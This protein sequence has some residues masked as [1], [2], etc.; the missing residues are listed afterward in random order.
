MGATVNTEEDAERNDFRP[1]LRSPHRVDRVF[2]ESAGLDA[3]HVRFVGST[4]MGVP[5]YEILGL[6]STATD[7]QGRSIP[8]PGRGY[9]QP[10]E[11]RARARRRTR[12]FRIEEEDS[13]EISSALWRIFERK[14]LHKR[15]HANLRNTQ[16]VDGVTSSIVPTPQSPHFVVLLLCGVSM[17]TTSP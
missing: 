2:V 14:I 3:G 13:F 8:K 15:K 4:K 9:R 7:K 12:L 17:L 1:K 16:F 10:Q 11:K 5:I 6:A